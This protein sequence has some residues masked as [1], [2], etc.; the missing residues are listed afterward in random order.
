M[1]DRGLPP[2][3]IS[4]A[5][6]GD[7]SAGSVISIAQDFAALVAI[8]DRQLEFVSPSDV[9]TLT[10]IRNAKQAAERGAKLS[11]KLVALTNSK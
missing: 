2:V 8:F 4:D 5:Q 7:D 9:E 11:E 1:Q 3:G 10:H 6:G